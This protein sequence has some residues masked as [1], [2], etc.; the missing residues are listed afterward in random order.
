LWD[1]NRYNRPRFLASPD[2]VLKTGT[3]MQL[4]SPYGGTLQLVFSNATPQQT[5]QLRLRGVAKHPFLD[6]S[7]GA[8]D[9]AAFVTALNAAQHEWAHATAHGVGGPSREL[10]AHGGD[11]DQPRLGIVAE[12]GPVG[13]VHIA[14]I[15]DCQLEPLELCHEVRQA[16]G[17][18]PHVHA[19]TAGAE[20]HGD[21]DELD[22]AWRG[23][24]RSPRPA[25]IRRS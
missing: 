21:T 25:P 11:G 8:G 17:R 7:N 22:G 6:Q 19:A 5:V 12:R 16:H 1:P 20:V 2:M 24:S 4:V 3:V 15:V 18:R 14:G 10:G 9:K 23:R 13:D